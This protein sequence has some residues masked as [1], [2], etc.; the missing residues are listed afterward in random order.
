[1]PARKIF[2]RSCLTFH[3]GASNTTITG[4]ELTGTSA[5]AIADLLEDESYPLRYHLGSMQLQAVHRLMFQNLFQPN[6][7]Q[8]WDDFS[9]V[10]SAAGRLRDELNE[11][12]AEGE[13]SNESIIEIHNSATWA[14]DTHKKDAVDIAYEK[15]GK[16]QQRSW[17]IEA[18]PQSV[19]E[20]L[21]DTSQLLDGLSPW[22]W[23]DVSGILAL[24][25]IDEAAVYVNVR[26][27]YKAAA[28]AIVAERYCGWQQ[29]FTDS[30]GA[31]LN[32][33]TDTASSFSAQGLAIRHA[34]NR[35]LKAQAI[36]MYESKE[37]RSQADAARKIAAKVNRTEKVVEKWLR[38]YRKE[39]SEI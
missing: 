14:T 35:A 10:I 34:K 19:F 21:Y 8:R 5:V 30:I 6:E 22:T 13:F 28:W 37:W 11:V 15:Y 39:N 24:W 17:V 25:S 32:L 31:D 4:Q 38:A 12:I 20:C 1:M 18:D 23:G 29:A 3:N 16:S 33:Q 7:S 27:P 26:E 36:E 9:Y 2:D